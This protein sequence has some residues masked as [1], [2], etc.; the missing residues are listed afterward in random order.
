MQVFISLLRCFWSSKIESGK[1]EAWCSAFFCVK[2][3]FEPIFKIFEFKVKYI[4]PKVSSLGEVCP[5][6]PNSTKFSSPTDVGH[7]NRHQI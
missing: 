7:L 6:S 3:L 1:G 2:K 5:S 4:R